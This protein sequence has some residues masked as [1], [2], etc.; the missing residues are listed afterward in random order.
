[1]S[2]ARKPAGVRDIDRAHALSVLRAPHDAQ[3]AMYSGGE[4]EAV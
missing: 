4:M 1:M 3:N 2:S